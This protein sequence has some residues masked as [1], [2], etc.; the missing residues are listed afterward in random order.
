MSTRELFADQAA[1]DLLTANG[2][3]GFDALWTLEVAWHEAPNER[4]GGW[5]GVSR[6]VLHDG[7][8]VFLK[9]QDNHLCRTLRHPLRGIPTFYREYANIQRLR[10]LR[11]AAVEALY[12]GDRR[13]ADHWRAILVTRAL[14][15]FISLDEWNDSHPPASSPLRQTVVKAVAHA[16]ARL[17][18]HRLQHSCLYGKHLFI[19]R[20]PEADNALGEADVRF[21]DLEKLRLGFSRKGVGAHDI[22]QLMRHTPGWTAQDREAFLAAYQQHCQ[23]LLHGAGTG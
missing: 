21:I 1:Q 20:R 23:H 15:E 12:Y 18:H 10:A 9:R 11:I 8:A 2:L 19:K 4:R 6:H 7:T 5:S 14:D 3:A 17:H 22:D 16:C 13:S